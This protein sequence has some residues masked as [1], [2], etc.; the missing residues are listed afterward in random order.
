MND[1]SSEPA[2]TIIDWATITATVE[3]PLCSYNLR[4]L[5]EP[6]CPECGYRFQW[7]ELLDPQR[8]AHRYIFEHHRRRHIWSFFRTLIGGLRTRRFWTHLRP[9]DVVNPKRLAIYWLLCCCFLLMVPLTQYLQIA[10][11]LAEY[12]ATTRRRISPKAVYGPLGREKW[13]NTYL[14]LPPHP[15]FFREVSTRV[16]VDEIWSPVNATIATI[17]AWPWLTFA[18]LMI[19]QASMRKAMVRRSHVLRCVIY[20]SDASVWYLLVT[21]LIVATTMIL[22]VASAGRI[23]DLFPRR[24]M[25]WLILLLWL[26][27]L[28]RLATAYRRYLRFDHPFLT[29]FSSQILVALAMLLLLLWAGLVF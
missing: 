24:W 16:A 26:V 20:S 9:I 27:R 4:G 1:A 3:C 23:S 8:A 13:L 10:L 7:A 11:P 15:E 21:F 17:L 25:V 5:L 2:P 18:A 12:N 22:I 14:P 19:F 6:R 28:D 29:A